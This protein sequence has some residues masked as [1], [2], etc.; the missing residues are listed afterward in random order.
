MQRL[1][2][3]LPLTKGYLKN[4]TEEEKK[5]FRGFAR[6]AYNLERYGM[7][8]YLRRIT[9]PGTTGL[10]SNIISLNPSQYLSIDF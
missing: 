9:P 1:E 8:E 5:D 2:N 7:F 10:L 6:K 4:L 3:C